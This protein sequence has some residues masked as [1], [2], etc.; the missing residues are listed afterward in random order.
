MKDVFLN[1]MIYSGS[2]LMAYN[3]YRYI[4]FSRDV[5][6]HGNWDQEQR[7]FY[8]PILLLIMFFAGYLIVGLFGDPD[9]VMAGI[10]FGG[11]IFVFVM[12]HLIRRTFER[13]KENEQLEVRLSAAEEANK[14]KTFFLS[15][16]SHDIRTPLNA[17]IGYTTLANR[18]GVTYEEKSGFIDKIDIASRQL[19]DIVN[20][21]LDMSRIESGKFSLEPGCVDLE[22]CVRE[23]C[24]LVRIQLE[25]KKIELSVSC[26][27]SHK[28]VLCD[29]VMLDRALMNLLCNA[30]KFTE[31]NGSVS[32]KLTELPG[33]DETGSYEIRIKDTGI[34]MSREFIE[35]LFVP[36][37]RERTS[38][39]SR[40][41]GTGLGLAITKSIVDM[42]GGKI[43]VLTEKGKG[44][45]FTITVDFPLAEPEEEICSC[46]GDDI[47]FEGLRALLVE[48]NMINMEI[49]QM[50]LEQAGFLIETAENGKIAVEMTAASEPGYYDVILMDIQMPVMDGYTAT[51]AI[52]TLPDAGLA[53]IPIIAMTAN[54]FQEDIKKA[55]EVGMN[56]HIAKPLDIRS[57]K[58]TLQHV[59]KNVSG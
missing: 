36:F 53:D 12:L 13:I 5:R 25:A 22:N 56:G 24:D 41:Q 9:L 6:K 2:A 14:A 30:G 39:V 57:M 3:I 34:G 50:L 4:C 18:E 55:E 51:K 19:L 31:E 7:L 16:M 48:D 58:A 28:W 37:E 45:E 47:S 29:K 23:V 49:A 46:E 52:R 59:L 8:L 11:S 1:L 54:A 33:S 32:L 10:L 35:H 40:T 42:M 17:I 43:A 38:T 21:V 26:A 27:V 20:D 44:T 15:N